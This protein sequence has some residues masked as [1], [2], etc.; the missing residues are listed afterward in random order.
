[1]KQYELSTDVREALRLQREAIDLL[2][3]CI[4]SEFDRAVE[5]ILH[6]NGVVATGVGKS[7]LIARKFAASLASIGVRATYIH[8]VDAVHG[9]LGN[10]YPSS[11]LVL[12]SKS[13]ETVE[14]N[15]LV[16]VLPDPSVQTVCITSRKSSTLSEHCDIQL[17]APIVR[18][19]DSSNLLPTASTT[20]ALILADLLVVRVA[21]QKPDALIALERSH[22]HGTIGSLLS[23]QVALYMHSGEST[24]VCDLATSVQE[25]VHILDRT[26]LGIVC[27]VDST[28]QL[29]GVLTDGDVRRLVERGCALESIMIS[30]VMTVEPVVVGPTTSLH[31]A[32]LLMESRDRQIGVVPVV[33]NRKLLGVIRLHDIVRAQLQS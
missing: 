19:Y 18:E 26:A 28:S 3:D 13:G 33:E 30:E 12:F 8:P 2:A 17:I 20:Q 5:A 4:D 22:P 24:P 16:R 23:K 1:M 6:A 10:V 9:D 25:A 27:V 29:V 14:L 15:E 32:L 21:N 11:V 7:G 31:Q